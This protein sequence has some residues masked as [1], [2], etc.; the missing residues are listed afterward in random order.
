MLSKLCKIDM[1]GQKAFMTVEYLIVDE[2]V[3]VDRD[4][5]E[6]ERWRV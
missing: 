2:E 3:N 4:R 5:E 1:T 6:G